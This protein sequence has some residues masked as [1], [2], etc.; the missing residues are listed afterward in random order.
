LALAQAIP[1][2]IARQFLRSV[3]PGVV[4]EASNPFNDAASVAFRINRLDLFRRR[5][6]E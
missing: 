6:L 1:V 5:G 4:P 2:V 3:R